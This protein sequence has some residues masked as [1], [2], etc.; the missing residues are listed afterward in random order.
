[1]RGRIRGGAGVTAIAGREEFGLVSVRGV[2][3]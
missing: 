3:D 2:S 1:M